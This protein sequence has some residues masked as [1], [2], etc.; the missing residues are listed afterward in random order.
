M[1]WVERAGIAVAVF[2][3]AM[4]I[5]IVGF[6]LIKGDE[7]K[8]Q[9]LLAMRQLTLDLARTRA[10]N[11]TITYT[12]ECDYDKI[13]DVVT[14][15][16]LGTSDPFVLAAQ[17]VAKERE[18]AFGVYDCDQY[19]SEVA[20]RFKNMGYNAKPIGVGVDC[21]SGVW[22]KASCDRSSGRHTIVKI[23]GPIYVE[24]TSGQFILPK[25]YDIFGVKTK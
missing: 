9:N 4:V 25:D 8:D 24:A 11:T 20:H 5:F 16:C 13:G 12:Q 21:N 3:I 1:N 10:H 23:E 7:M 17:L 14:K 2:I 6:I 19:A 18:Y 15:K 22:D